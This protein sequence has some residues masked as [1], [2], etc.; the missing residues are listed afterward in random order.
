MAK[1]IDMERVE[2]LGE[3][4]IEHMLDSMQE[5]TEYINLDDVNK[6]L[7]DDYIFNQLKQL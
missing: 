4:V 3:Q 7:V 5:V 2:I 6:E 1:K